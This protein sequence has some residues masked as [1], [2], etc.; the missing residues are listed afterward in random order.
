MG[1]AESHNPLV[2]AGYDIVWSGI[3]LLILALLIIALVS[4]SRSSKHLTSWQALGWTLLVIFV[5]AIGVLA[6]FAIGRR[7][8]TASPD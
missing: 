4:I 1:M 2:P 5:P 8:L 7:T 6:W 3:A